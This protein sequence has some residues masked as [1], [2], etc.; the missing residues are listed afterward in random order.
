MRSAVR[1]EIKCVSG[2]YSRYSDCWRPSLVKSHAGVIAM[3][4]F[5]S[6]LNAVSKKNSRRLSFAMAGCIAA[7]VAAYAQLASA[8]PSNACS[9]VILKTQADVNAFDQNC[10]IIDG[11]LKIDGKDLLWWQTPITNLTPLD[12]VQSANSLVVLSTT[13]LK[14]LKGLEGLQSV[15]QCVLIQANAVL[16]SLTGLEGLRT[17]GGA[18]LNFG[19]SACATGLGLHINDNASLTDLY[20]LKNLTSATGSLVLYNND[21]LQN[22]VGLRGLQ[23][24][25]DDFQI[26]DNLALRNLDGLEGITEVDTL[27]IRYNRNLEHVDALRNMEYRRIT[28]QNAR[29]FEITENWSLGRCEGLAPFFRWPG[30]WGLP[31]GSV[32][33]E[34]N[35]QGCNS[36]EEIWASVEVTAP[37]VASIEAENGRMLLEFSPATSNTSLYPIQGHNVGCETTEALKKF[38]F[39]ETSIPDGELTTSRHYFSTGARQA[40][41]GS[42]NT[43]MAVWSPFVRIWHPNPD[44]LTASVITP[45]GE[46]RLLLDR[47]DFNPGND[48]YFE[49]PRDVWNVVVGTDD[50]ETVFPDGEWSPIQQ[51][52][53]G[54]YEIFLQDSSVT[55]SYGRLNSWGL[56]IGT[57]LEP[58]DLPV[59]G[60]SVL[61][62]AVLNDV[63]NTC[64]IEPV[65]S[66]PLDLSERK[67]FFDFRSELVEPDGSTE[68][69]SI[70]PESGVE[71]S[72]LVEVRQTWAWQSEIQEYLVTC[73]AEGE[74]PVYGS[75]TAD[76]GA[77]DQQMNADGSVTQTIRVDGLNEEK[78]YTCSVTAYNRRGGGS[79]SATASATTEAVSRGLPIWLLYEATQSQ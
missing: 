62:D 72:L 19:T 51:G 67:T 15:S 58:R 33:F 13:N 44:E 8:A 9:S 65:T 75:A 20:G 10:E 46:E 23:A 40:R 35:L 63:D 18:A 36:L 25:L 50:E 70:T 29:V 73:E 77:A 45:W 6:G 57:A 59:Q 31:A 49:F 43:L 53:Q 34:D 61:F 4:P 69:V 47:F 14:D 22:I 38:T 54:W 41:Q 56:T 17:I 7:L 3:I 27:L 55:P 5:L 52:L 11:Y 71:A 2:A 64:V 68:I 26:W 39:S 42:K 32:D 78:A 28:S 60:N 24:Q 74:E 76:F 66:T 12:H 30:N 79:P 48:N 21:R 37:Q 16:D 1:A